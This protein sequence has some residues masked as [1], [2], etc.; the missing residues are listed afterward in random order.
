[1]VP[2]STQWANLKAA[3]GVRFQRLPVHAESDQRRF[4]AGDKSSETSLVSVLPFANR[5]PRASTKPSYRSL[6]DACAAS[7]M[8]SGSGGVVVSQNF[9][10]SAIASFPIDW[11]RSKRSKALVSQS[12]RRTIAASRWSAPSGDRNAA[13]AASTI[14]DFDTLRRAAKASSSPES[15]GS[16]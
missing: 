11:S 9:T 7:R 15:D 16:K 4:V 6:P 10:K 2:S 5:R 14:C 8:P 13:N 1:M 3:I 12:R